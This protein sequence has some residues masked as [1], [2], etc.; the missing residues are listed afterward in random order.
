MI[1]TPASSPTPKNAGGTSALAEGAPAPASW[2]TIHRADEIYKSGKTA[3]ETSGNIKRECKQEALRCLRELR[4]MVGRLLESHPQEERVSEN[5][6]KM[7]QNL[8][9][10]LEKA[11]AEMNART[12][13]VSRYSELHNGIGLPDSNC[14]T[15]NNIDKQI[16]TISQENTNLQLAITDISKKVSDLHSMVNRMGER[17]DFPTLPYTTKPP[18]STFKPALII[19]STNPVNSHNETLT[20][21]HNSI[22]FRNTDFAPIKVSYVSNHKLKVEFENQ[23]Q[24]SIT[25]DKIKRSNSTIA[26][27]PVKKLKPMIIL[28]GISN[29]IAPDQIKPIM[30]SQNENIKNATSNEND[31]TLK[32]KRANKNP[33]LYNAIFMVTPKI[34]TAITTSG[35]V[36]LDHQK[37]HAE[38]YIPLLQCYGCMQFGHT[39]KYCKAP[40]SLVCSHC[41]STE[42]EYKNCPH[43]NDKNM[44]ECYNCKAQSKKF[45]HS[46][47]KTTKTA[48]SATSNTCPLAIR[49]LNEVRARTDNG[50]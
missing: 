37:V 2:Q 30:M 28:K 46:T 23:E 15:I 44:L 36:N 48:H 3:I 10:K 39:R 41:A 42:H 35:R 50:L 25:L 34:W 45:N 6:E 20:A 49:K 43:K 8:C 27:E 12:A 4:D 9:N 21:W 22:N 47:P 29:R 5:L 40:S 7:E 33:E 38:E 18:T 14:L 13:D 11:L 26:A 19:S 17:T 1:R 24:C 16:E 31:I 32:L